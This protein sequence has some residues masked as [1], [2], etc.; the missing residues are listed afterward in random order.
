MKRCLTAWKATLRGVLR[1][2]RAWRPSQASTGRGNPPA[3]GEVAPAVAMRSSCSSSW[4][5]GRARA[6]VSR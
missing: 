3:Q 5:E 4:L 2:L 1:A 6:R